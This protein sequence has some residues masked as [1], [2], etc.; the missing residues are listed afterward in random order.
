M[1]S[2]MQNDMRIAGV[3]KDDVENQMDG[4]QIVGMIIIM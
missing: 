3:R 2:F 1:L 4:P